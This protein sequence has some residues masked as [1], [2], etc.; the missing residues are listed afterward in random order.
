LGSDRRTAGLLIV[1][2]IPAV[3][4]G[5]PLKM[6][7]EGWLESSLL[8]GCLLPVTGVILLVA[9]R[10]ADWPTNYPELSWWRALGI[11]LSQALAILPGLSRSGTTI[12]AGM[13]LGL[14][15]GAA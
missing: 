5:F 9:G 11:G 15:P 8:A 6:Y 13:C 1:A 10:F 4:V 7:A 2:T 14:A 12:S 3:L